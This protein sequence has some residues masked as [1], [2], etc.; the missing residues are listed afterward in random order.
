MDTSGPETLELE[1]C[2]LS[3][4]KRLIAKPD[5]EKNNILESVAIVAWNLPANRTA[6]R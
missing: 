3:V 5:I 6:V 4:T 1:Q 2:H